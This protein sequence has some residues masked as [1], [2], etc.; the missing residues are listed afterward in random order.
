VGLPEF[1]L[2]LAFALNGLSFFIADLPII[3]GN[4]AIVGEF[5]YIDRAFAG[6]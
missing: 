6:G 3:I 2:G 1:C 5:I 4:E